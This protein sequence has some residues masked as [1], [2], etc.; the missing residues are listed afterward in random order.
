MCIWLSCS[1]YWSIRL[2]SRPNSCT[3]IC[4]C[5]YTT[6]GACIAG[7]SPEFEPEHE[8]D[9]M[10]T[11]VPHRPGVYRM[12]DFHLHYGGVT[13]RGFELQVGGRH[14]QWLNTCPLIFSLCLWCFENNHR[15]ERLPLIFILFR[16][17]GFA[18]VEWCLPVPNTQLTAWG[19]RER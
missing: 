8:E 14:K 15:F 4:T 11:D 19:L 5:I 6:E 13:G 17:C 2:E 16:E 3:C 18:A 1:T 12:H 10:V 9:L 7:H